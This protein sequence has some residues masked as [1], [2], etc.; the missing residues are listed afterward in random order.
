MKSQVF[1]AACGL[2][3]LVTSGF[4]YNLNQQNQQL[5]LKG[6]I[7]EAENRLLQQEVRELQYKQQTSRTYDDGYNDA[8]ARMGSHQGTYLD[9]WLAAEKIYRDKTYV[10]G[11][12]A[13]TEQIAWSQRIQ[14]EQLPKEQPKPQTPPDKYGKTE[15]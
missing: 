13:A 3:A 1:A 9:G 14:Q 11:Y 8:L 5:S 4:A 7:Y 15:K 2:F 6:M 10:D 12:H